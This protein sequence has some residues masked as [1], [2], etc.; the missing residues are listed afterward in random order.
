MT[1]KSKY[2]YKIGD[3]IIISKEPF[4]W[5]SALSNKCPLIAYL[6]YPYKCVIVDINYD[7]SSFVDNNGYGWCLIDLLEKDIIK[8]DKWVRKQK[9]SKINGLKT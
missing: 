4:F 6:E 9:L 7:G 3:N 2:D 5:S 8:N 1:M